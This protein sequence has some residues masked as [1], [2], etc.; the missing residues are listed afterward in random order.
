MLTCCFL[1]FIEEQFK[2]ETR[3]IA[4]DFG[5]SDIYSKIEV[6]L[7][8]LEIGVLGKRCFNLVSCRINFSLNM[9]DA[10]SWNIHPFCPYFNSSLVFHLVSRLVNCYVYGD[11]NDQG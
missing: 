5:K 4:V 2:I 8:G 11:L 6:G 7:A 10:R 1:L 9:Y 3:T